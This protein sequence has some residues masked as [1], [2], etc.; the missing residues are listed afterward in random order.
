MTTHEPAWSDQTSDDAGKD[1]YHVTACTCGEKPLPLTYGLAWFADHA[2]R[3]GAPD[4][5]V[6]YWGRWAEY[7]E[8]PTKKIS[9][10]Q[11]ARELFDYG[12]VMDQASQVYSELAGL[13]KPNTAATH[14][15]SAAE[16]RYAETYAD[17][18][19]DHADNAASD[20]KPELAVA[21]RIIADGWSEGATERW[22]ESQR[23]AAEARARMTE[24]NA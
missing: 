5:M 11:V 22:D 10:D 13:S 24:A 21:L 1:E 18:L 23:Y 15:L 7:V 19:C 6:E 12:V 4:Y 14:I 17:H 16:E 20:G 3:T 9:R 2:K 8:A